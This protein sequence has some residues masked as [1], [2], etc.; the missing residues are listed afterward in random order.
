MTKTTPLPLLR[1]AVP[2]IAMAIVLFTGRPI[3]APDSGTFMAVETSVTTGID[4]AAQSQEAGNAEAAR[5]RA[6]QA[7]RLRWALTLPDATRPL[8]GIRPQP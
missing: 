5:Q 8:R 1:L 2:V 4:E 6:H 3:S 7:R